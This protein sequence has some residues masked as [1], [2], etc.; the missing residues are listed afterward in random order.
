MKL[1]RIG[2]VTVSGFVGLLMLLA[3]NALAVLMRAAQ[4]VNAEKSNPPY[5]ATFYTSGTLRIEAYLYKPGGAGPFPLVIYNHGNDRAP[6][7]ERTELPNRFIGQLLTEAGYAVLVP[8]RRGFGKSDGQTFAEEVGADIDAKLTG[9]VQAETDDVL[10]GIEYARTEPSINTKRIAIMGYST[11]GMVTVFAASRSGAFVA[12]IAQASG[13]L[14][15]DKSPALRKTLPEAAGKIRIP[16]L[17][18]VAENDATTAAVQSVYDAAHAHGAAAEL[19]IYPPFKPSDALAS[20]LSNA[21]LA[22][23]LRTAPGHL[24]FTPEGMPIWS[25]DVLAFLGKNLRG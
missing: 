8:E 19:V 5:T 25:K 14:N 3:A 2:P 21:G 12:A 18:M 10:A 4:D 17:C 1:T 16:I 6:G 9:R 13:S 23:L 7:R 20:S 22:S 11:G 15:W 24:I